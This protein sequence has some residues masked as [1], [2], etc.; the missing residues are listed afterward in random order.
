M[1]GK[2]NVRRAP[3]GIACRQGLRVE[4]VEDG[5]GQVT[6]TQGSLDRRLV[7]HRAAADID[8]ARAGFHQSKFPGADDVPGVRR[9]G[10][11][12]HDN[13]GFGQEAVQIFEGMHLFR[14]RMRLR[15]AADAEHA[16]AQR[17]SGLCHGPAHVAQAHHEQRLAARRSAE[18]GLPLPARLL[19]KDLRHARIEHEQTHQPEL[20]DFLHVH[21]AVVGEPHAAVDPVERHEAFDAGADHVDPGQLR[22]LCGKRAQREAFVEQGGGGAH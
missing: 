12:H 11:G 22:R 3:Q 14:M 8:Q 17:A 10:R 19:R 5:A 18:Y 13:V 20:V 15:R 6:G 7:Q 2:I 21:A 9:E 4:N 1:R 16:H